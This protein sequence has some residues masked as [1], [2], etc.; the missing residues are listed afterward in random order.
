M[1]ADMRAVGIGPYTLVTM[2]SAALNGVCSERLR[3]RAAGRRST[4]PAQDQSYSGVG[5][6]A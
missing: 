1:Q 5:G 4:V 2:P 3:Q 6:G